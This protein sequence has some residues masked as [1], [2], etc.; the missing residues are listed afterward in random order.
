MTIRVATLYRF[1]FVTVVCIAGITSA[2]QSRRIIDGQPTAP[3]YLRVL[4]TSLVVYKAQY[5]TF[6]AALAALGPPQHT[7]A[8]NAEAANL[9][10]AKL[11]SGVYLA[12]VFH[13][14][15][16]NPQGKTNFEAFTITA[17][18]AGSEGSNGEYYFVD[19]T[20]AIRGE[21][22]IR[23]QRPAIQ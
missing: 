5:K 16:I 13:Y 11:A 6:P 14:E 2:C 19:E 22:T 21:P 15:P 18:P 20:G 12:Y 4:T 7:G 1:V 9:V 17:E 23:R 8:S 3:R 10:D